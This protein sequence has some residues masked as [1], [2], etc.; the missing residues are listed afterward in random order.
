MHP[1]YEL[2]D[3][4]RRFWEERLEAWL[5]KR[6][7]DAHRHISRPEHV[8]PVTLG[9]SGTNWATEVGSEES[10]EE[11]A[12]GYAELFP[13]REVS[14]LAFGTPYPE[15][16][17]EE[18][19][20]YLSEG[21]RG[22]GSAAL[23]L[24]RP[25][26]TPEQVL[27]QLRQPGI[28]GLKPYMGMWAGWQGG[29]C[30][31]FEYMT[32]EHL[33]LLD[34]LGGWLTLHIPRGERLADPANIKEILELRQRY[35]RLVLVVAHLGRAY[36]GRY[37]REGFRALEREE[38]LLWDTSA[39]LNPAVLTLALDRLGPEKL[40]WAT[41]LP[42]LYM[43]GRRRWEGDQYINLTSG[44]YSW[45]TQRE[46][47]EVEAGYTLYLY[48]SL[49]ALVDAAVQLGYGAAELEAILHENARRKMDEVAARKGQW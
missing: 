41:D 25:E 6:V 18:M 4:D 38:G 44:D 27:E 13:G 16:H 14:Y 5:P 20:A 47:P 10:L 33:A 17:T 43:R 35:P 31:I 12:I 7:V 11:A 8:D 40:L 3:V 37:A 42:I 23:A 26:W 46:A 19:N 30:S 45:N 22:T 49:A 21:V 15:G 1:R 24:V 32:H 9:K 34:E 29:D 2:K 39:V 36:A 48:E 28:L